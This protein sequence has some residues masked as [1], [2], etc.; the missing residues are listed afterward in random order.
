MNSDTRRG[1]GFGFGAYLLWG[2]FPL[3]F[4][5][6]DRSGALEILL[7]RILWSL[8]LCFVLITVGRSWDELRAVFRSARQTSILT[9]AAALIAV[10]WGV[11][12]YAVNSGQVVEASLGYFINPL[13]T[14]ALGVL[15]LRERLRVTQWTA[16]GIGVVA[17][18]V[19][20]VDYGHVPVIALSLAC[21]FG[22]YGLL[23]NT[24]GSG[25]DGV[26]AVAGLT[27][28]TLVLAPFAAITVIVLSLHGDSTFTANPPW[29]ALLLA[30][31]GLITVG[32]LLLFASAARRVPLTTMGLLQYLTPVLQLLCGVLVLGEHM[33][34]SRWIGF[35]LVW[36]ALAVL[37]F[38]SLRAA[39][40]NY[41]TRA[42]DRE[43][44]RA[45]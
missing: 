23:K 37:T 42:V 32:P 38:D 19:L 33:P 4:R 21:S 36:T 18:A 43:L 7:H 9:A 3:Y 40:R 44:S 35:A 26:G 31:T 2:I 22:T 24:V 41:R 10:N 13:V 27:T 28:E 5:L 16:V 17:V 8:I 12:I 11:Y 20:T 14:V 1:V 6:L 25:T 29:Q 15:V 45:A 39:R 34:P 30:S